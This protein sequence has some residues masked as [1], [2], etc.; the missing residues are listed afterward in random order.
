MIDY[1]EGSEFLPTHYYY[2]NGAMVVRVEDRWNGVSYFA[3]N[4]GDGT[5]L[6]DIELVALWG[7]RF[8]Y[9]AGDALFRD[10]YMMPIPNG[11]I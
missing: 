10:N 11:E 9:S 4:A 1:S 6:G 8:A 2:C 5:L 3:R 7:S